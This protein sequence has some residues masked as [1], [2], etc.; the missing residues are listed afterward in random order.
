[1]NKNSNSD[2]IIAL[3]LID[4]DEFKQINDTHGHKAGDNLLKSVAMRILTASRES[5]LILSKRYKAARIGGDEFLVLYQIPK[6][7]AS[8]VQS[9][10]NRIHNKI[11]A[12]VSLGENTLKPSLSI[13]IALSPQHSNNINQLIDFADKAMYQAKFSGGNCVV[14]YSSSV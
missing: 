6:E 1:M 4:I 9:I 10:A 5:E 14:V 7:E 12:T 8:A 2:S 13:G 3:L 11:S